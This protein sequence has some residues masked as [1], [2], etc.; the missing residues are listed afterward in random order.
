MPQRTGRQIIRDVQLPL[1]PNGLDWIKQSFAAPDFPVIAPQGIPDKYVGRTLPV[2]MKRTTSLTIP[3]DDY[4]L[5]IAPIPGYAFFAADLKAA[6]LRPDRVF[7]GHAFD[8]ASTLFPP[9][10]LNEP[11]TGSDVVTGFR[12]MSQLVELVPTTNQTSWSGSIQAFRLPAR[13]TLA[14]LSTQITAVD[15]EGSKS[16]A[17]VPFTQHVPTGLEGLGA[18]NTDRYVAPS[19][20]GVFMSALN[21]DETFSFAET[22][23]T[24]QLRDTTNR[25]SYPAGAEVRD[26]YHNGNQPVGS[27][28]TF[29]SDGTTNTPLAG[30]GNLDTLVIRVTGAANNT[31]ILRNWASLEC[32]IN[33]AS[34]LY[35]YTKQ[36]PECDLPAISCYN[37]IARQAPIA[38]SYYDNATFWETVKKIAGKIFNL[39]KPVAT[40]LTALPGPAGLIS[41]GISQILN[42]L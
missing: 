24:F 13:D 9:Q 3:S 10:L 28:G 41:G 8:E 16:L 34:A 33:P 29:V 30:W 23:E 40:A 6:P 5:I 36:S 26:Q 15:V 21:Q 18:A 22:F 1:T 32:Q 12:Y 2:Q 42:A 7:V 14:T 39:A 27:Y 25:V 19:N 31:F 20:L 11:P 37:M 38:V 17:T 4:L 35:S